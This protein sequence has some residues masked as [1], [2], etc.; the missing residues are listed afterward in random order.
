MIRGRDP[1][2][3]PVCARLGWDPKKVHQQAKPSL[4]QRMW[5]K[6]AN[7]KAVAQAGEQIGKSMEQR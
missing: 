3:C 7:S 5:S 6:F 1:M 4:W 2:N